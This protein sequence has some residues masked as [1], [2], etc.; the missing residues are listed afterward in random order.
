[1]KVQTFLS[2]VLDKTQARYRDL[3]TDLFNRR[4]SL[5]TAE[6][7]FRTLVGERYKY[8]ADLKQKIG[9]TINTMFEPVETLNKTLTGAI[10]PVATSAA[11]TAAYEQEWKQGDENKRIAQLSSQLH[12][13]LGAEKNADGTAKYDTNKIPTEKLA[14]FAQLPTAAEAYRAAVDYLVGN[15]QGESASVST[16]TG[17]STGASSVTAKASTGAKTTGAT[18]INVAQT[19]TSIDSA[20]K[21]LLEQ[22]KLLNAN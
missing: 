19:N 1:M 17:T 20:K 3:Y 18:D 4:S 2:D 13:F 7:S 10:T 12:N 11:T 15:S 5:T 6:Q 16:S 14:E 8:L 9:E 21:Y 22:A